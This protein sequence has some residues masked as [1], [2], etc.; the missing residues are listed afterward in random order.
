MEQ[1]APDWYPDVRQSRRRPLSRQRSRTKPTP[2]HLRYDDHNRCA[3]GTSA[4]LSSLHVYEVM[5]SGAWMPVWAWDDDAAWNRLIEWMNANCQNL[6]GRLVVTPKLA[7]Q[8]RRPDGLRVI[9]DGAAR[10][11]AQGNGPGRNWAG[12]APVIGVWPHDRMVQRCVDL[13]HGQTLIL[14]EQSVTSDQTSFAGW[15]ST[16]GAFNA[17]AGEHEQPDLSLAAQLDHI[18]TSFEN[19]LAGPPP[20]VRALNFYTNGFESCPPVPTRISS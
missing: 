6:S 20:A 9:A 1:P 12:G 17:E 18:I 19:E 13:A 11:D 14:L 5:H 16:V 3:R 7:N 10:Q 4:R 8:L 15:A 2:L